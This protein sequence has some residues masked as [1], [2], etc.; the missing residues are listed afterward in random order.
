MV[1]TSS[2]YL[3]SIY[4]IVYLLLVLLI[5]GIHTKRGTRYEEILIRSSNL[6]YEGNH[7][8][9][10]FEIY[11]VKKYIF[12]KYKKSFYRVKMN[13][14]EED[15]GIGYIKEELD[16]HYIKPYKSLKNG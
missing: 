5:V 12:G 10:N 1:V 13:I 9:K 15:I 14:T 7:P 16:F 2:L 4:L 6:D 11:L 8:F 3:Y